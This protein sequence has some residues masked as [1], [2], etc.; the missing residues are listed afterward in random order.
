[1]GLV[2]SGVVPRG[3]WGYG[4]T[5]CFTTPPYHTHHLREIQW[6]HDC[7]TWI[8][9][10]AVVQRR[11]GRELNRTGGCGGMSFFSYATDPPPLFFFVNMG[12]W[13]KRLPM[14]YVRV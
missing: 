5:V 3:V 13:L 9:G 7:A 10:I 1:M 4:V 12:P 6:Q 11:F 8:P 2:L 14:C